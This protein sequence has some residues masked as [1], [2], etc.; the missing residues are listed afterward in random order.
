MSESPYQNL[1]E[2]LDCIVASQSET[3]PATF[4]RMVGEAFVAEEIDAKQYDE[5][6]T[7]V[8]AYM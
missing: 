4:V 5:L 7:E 8:R 6:I 2:L 1:H 3:S